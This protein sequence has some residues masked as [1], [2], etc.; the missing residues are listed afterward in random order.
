MGTDFFTFKL[1]LGSLSTILATVAITVD[2]DE[3]KAKKILEQ[4]KLGAKV[5]NTKRST[6]F[7]NSLRSSLT[8]GATA[9]RSEVKEQTK[10]PLA[11]NHDNKSTEMTETD[12]SRGRSLTN[13]HHVT[14]NVTL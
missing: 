14:D 6:S 8:S 11:Y 12:F 3:R 5:L 10:S 9:T 4:R 2:E 13:S 7:I 1:Q